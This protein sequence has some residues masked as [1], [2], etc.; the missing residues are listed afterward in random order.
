[1]AFALSPEREQLA[2]QILTRYPDPRAA[3]IPLLHLCQQQHGWCSPEV[4]D[5]VARRIGVSTA[6]VLGVVTFYTSLFQKP[7]PPNVVWVCRTL[8]CDLRGAKVIQEHLER[9]LGCRPGGRSKDGKFALKKAECLAACG[10]APV[11]QINDRYYENLTLAELDRIL[12][13]IAARTAAVEPSE[14]RHQE[15]D[16]GGAA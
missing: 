3:C 5:Y 2:A 16:A 8:S 9:R 14:P 15:P 10:G 4:I 7:H 1:M 12:D 11:V 6:H 13:E